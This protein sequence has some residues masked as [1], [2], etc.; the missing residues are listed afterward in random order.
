MHWNPELSAWID[1][2]GNDVSL[3]RDMPSAR[4]RPSPGAITGAAAGRD[5]AS[6]R[7]GPGNPGKP[8]GAKDTR[9][10]RKRP[11]ITL[12]ILEH[13]HRHHGAFLSAL[14]ESDPAAYLRLLDTHLM[15]KSQW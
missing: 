13:F 5:E 10:R 1:D 11:N 3:Y 9:R 2:Q 8:K 12:D 15:P 6:G 4:P 7:F 14:S